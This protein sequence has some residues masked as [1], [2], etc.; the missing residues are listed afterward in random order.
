[1]NSLPYI[2]RHPKFLFENLEKQNVDDKFILHSTH[3][4]PIAFLRFGLADISD[5]SPNNMETI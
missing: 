4:K 1:M 5:L 3:E 2:S